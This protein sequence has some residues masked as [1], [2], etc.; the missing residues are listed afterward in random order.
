MHGRIDLRQAAESIAEQYD[1]R[2]HKNEGFQKRLEVALHKQQQSLPAITDQ[3]KLWRK[4]LQDYQKDIE[5]FKTSVENLKNK[6]E[7]EKKEKFEKVSES[8]LKLAPNQIL[9]IKNQIRK[10]HDEVERLTKEIRELKAAL[11]IA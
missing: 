1:E 10:Q 4:T 6:V 11:G 7:S 5:L 3:E 8:S 2:N 9:E